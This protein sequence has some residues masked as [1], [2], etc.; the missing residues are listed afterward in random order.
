[1]PSLARTRVM[2]VDDN[3]RV[4]ALVRELLAA[5]P[6]EVIEC[7]DGRSAEA[8]YA[9]AM[10]DWVLMDV[11]MPG[12]DGI[13]AAARIIGAH[14]EARIVMLTDHGDPAYRAAAR[15]AGARG[16]LLKEELDETLGP[17][18]LRTAE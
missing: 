15:A 12:M 7:G 18:L 11:A 17:L 16:Y 8:L 3:A 13:T 1:M 9:V 4:R 2:I 14:P 5:V 6:A 10:P